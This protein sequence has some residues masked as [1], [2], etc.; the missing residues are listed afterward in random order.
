[1]SMKGLRNKHI[2]GHIM[3]L[4]SLSHP[5]PTTARVLETGMLSSLLVTNPDI[6]AYVDY[7]IDRGYVEE[8]NNEEYRLK[9]YKLTSRGID[10]LEGTICDAGV[11]LGGA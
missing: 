5:S 10:L 8:I 9:Y 2:R 3:Y 4:L 7:L 1:M 11:I 6:S